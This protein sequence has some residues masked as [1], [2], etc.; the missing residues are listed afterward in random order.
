M[1]DDILFSVVIGCLAA[2]LYSLRI[3]VLNQRDIGKK[4][5]IKMR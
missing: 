1:L 2:I 4:L 3:I 5:K